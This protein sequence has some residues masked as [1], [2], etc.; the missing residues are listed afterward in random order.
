MGIGVFVPGIV[1]L[2]QLDINCDLVMGAH[3]ITLG[4]ARTVDGK[5]VSGLSKLNQCL[6]ARHYGELSHTGDTVA[7]KMFEFIAPTAE[8]VRVSGEHKYTTGTGYTYLYVNGAQIEVAVIHN[9]TSF[10]AFTFTS[11]SAVGAGD[12]V[13]LYLVCNA[14]GNT[15]H[16]QKIIASMERTI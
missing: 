12:L 13:Q 1:A 15:M 5:D 10:T 7:T 8:K 16:I 3:D 9:Q 6:V 4:A 14:G 2:N 11:A